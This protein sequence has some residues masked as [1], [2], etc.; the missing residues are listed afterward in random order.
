MPMDFDLDA[1]TVLLCVAGSR[2][3]GIHTEHSDVDVKGVAIPPSRYFHGYLHTFAQADKAEQM[4]VFAPLLTASEREV[5]ARE[6]LE[7]SVYNLVKFVRLAAD[8]NPNILDI[9][10]CRD[11]EV[12]RV[13]PAGRRLREAR[14]R[15]LSAKAK[16]TYSGYASAQLKR[17]RGH[18]QWLLDPPK[19]EPTRS[20]FGLPG[21]TLISSDQLAAAQAAVRKQVD[22]W[23]IDWGT[24]A[25]SERIYVQGQIT[26]H[27]GQVGAALGMTGDD[28]TWL[29]AARIVGLND[30]LIAVMQAERAY[31][32]A[33]RHWSQYHH[34]KRSR[35]PARAALEAAHGYDTKHAAHLV[36][37][38]RMCREILETGD[39]RVWRGDTDREEL[40]A[41]RRGAWSYDELIAWSDAEEE[42]LTALWKGGKLAVPKQVDRDGLDALVVELVQDHLAHQ[43]GM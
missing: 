4:A 33:R 23:E 8:C 15:F 1:A 12:R 30:N 39:V 5:V 31:G 13:A 25:D 27:L 41:V 42:A 9:L 10:F 24:L 21:H 20:E 6:K 7:G 40:L 3:Y 11:E 19:A 2:A 22:R 26:T 34:W 43:P 29:A 37:L 38:L 17:I 32:A 14:G 18:R 16:H 36:R 35:N 28:A